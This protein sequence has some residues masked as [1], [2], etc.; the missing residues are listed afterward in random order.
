GVRRHVAAEPLPVAPPLVW[1]AAAGHPGR[2]GPPPRH[3]VPGGA[4]A[5]HPSLALPL[6][7]PAAGHPRRRVVAAR[8]P[9]HLAPAAVDEGSPAARVSREPRLARGGLTISCRPRPRAAP[10]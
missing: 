2:V 5:L 6:P 10:G 1:E 3:P 9:G 4:P 7:L 8:A